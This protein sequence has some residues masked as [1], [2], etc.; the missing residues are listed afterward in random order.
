VDELFPSQELE[1]MIWAAVDVPDPSPRFLT[2]L[3]EKLDA[4]ARG[5]SR[6]VE[7]PRSR[8]ELFRQPGWRI[9]FAI[10]VVAMLVVL[11]IGPQRVLAQVQ[12][13]LGYVSGVGF[14]ELDEPM[15]LSAPVSVRQGEITVVVNQVVAKPE[16]TIIL[17]S[18]STPGG[19]QAGMLPVNPEFEFEPRLLLPDG[20]HLNHAGMSRG[21]SDGT[22]E[23]PA[24]PKGTRQVTLVLNCIE[25]VGRGCLPGEWQ[26][27]LQLEPATEERFLGLV[28]Q[29]YDPQASAMANGVKMVV[30]Q[31]AHSDQETAVEV[32]FEWEN[33][34]WQWMGNARSSLS[35]D[36]G[37]LYEPEGVKQGGMTKIGF[38]L[39]TVVPPRSPQDTPTGQIMT[40]VE[41]HTFAPLSNLARRLTL[42][43]DWV[44]FQIPANGE[45]SFDLGPN[46][47]VGQTWT[48]DQDLQVAGFNVHLVGARLAEK[49][50]PG[51]SGEQEHTYWLEFFFQAE[52]QPDRWF[53]YFTAEPVVDSSVNWSRWSSEAGGGAHGM[54]LAF[55]TE[56]MPRGRQTYLID[57]AFLELRGSW[58]VSWLVPGAGMQ[59]VGMRRAHLEEAIQEQNGLLLKLEEALFADRFSRV[60]LVAPELTSDSELLYVL[61]WNSLVQ[62]ESSQAELYLLDEQGRRYEIAR[63]VWSPAG[64]ERF[65]P[66]QLEFAPLLADAGKLSLHVPGVELKLPGE[67]VF[68]VEVPKGLTFHE[69]QWTETRFWQEEEQE[70]TF[71]KVVSP[72]WDV[73]L[74]VDIAGYTVDFNGAYVQRSDQLDVQG[75][76]QLV[77]TGTPVVERQGE[78]WLREMTVNAIRRPDGT[79]WVAGGDMES[80]YHSFI[81]NV[82]IAPESATSGDLTATLRLDVGAAN[83]V[84]LL[85][86]TYEIELS[87]ATVIVP[88]PWDLPLSVSGD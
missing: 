3:G 46:P 23:F 28:S 55:G 17:L 9:A 72:A 75:G 7:Q 81:P 18:I 36:L 83:G 30:Q 88:G 48:E 8:F 29:P 4:R 73:D 51:D 33:S 15:I 6:S 74:Q 37:Y 2:E 58:Q 70:I 78:R 77:L 44:G 11:A 62:L 13:W 67:A 76:Y 38:P 69:E 22:I 86:G 61:G 20:S 39:Q 12:R 25:F 41:T 14:I 31:V 24:L 47:Q 26:I 21:L 64:E 45:F 43:V 66:S 57:G 35:D 32:K 54:K 60:Q 19:E 16:G 34:T 80:P 49:W 71:K 10:I 52:Q 40:Q 59:Q 27:G 84:D 65:D 82:V 53:T 42:S 87:G 50:E 85:P 1:R 63:G 56:Q 5:M 79:R 68:S